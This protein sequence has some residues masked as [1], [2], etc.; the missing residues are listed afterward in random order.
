VK[1]SELIQSVKDG[2]KSF[3]EGNYRAALIHYLQ[4]FKEGKEI[5]L[6]ANSST[7]LTMHDRMISCFEAMAIKNDSFEPIHIQL[8]HFIFENSKTNFTGNFQ[9]TAQKIILDSMINF[10]KKKLSIESVNIGLI[11]NKEIAKKII[12]NDGSHLYL[13]KPSFALDI[14]KESI[15]YDE[16]F[17][18]II[19]SPI[20]LKILKK[21]F[22]AN[23]MI[24]IFFSSIR[25][26]ILIESI[27][28]LDYLLKEEKINKFLLN[29]CFHSFRN[30]FC[31]IEKSQDNSNLEKL[32][33]KV[34]L[35]IDDNESI[36]PLEILVLLSYKPI[37]QYKKV[38]KDFLNHIDKDYFKELIDKQIEQRKKEEILQN[39]IKNITSIEDKTSN[40]V[41]K[42]YE[43][44]P[45]PRWDEDIKKIQTPYIGVIGNQTDKD[46][47]TI[48]IRK[49][50]VAG[51]GTGLQAINIA[52]FDPKVSIDA[53]DLSLN[54]LAYGKRQSQEMNIKN[55]NWYQA[56]ILNLEE[57][58]EKYDVIE[59]GGV[60]HHM[61]NPKKGFN[62]LSKKL[63]KNGFMKI[64]LYS[65]AYRETL[66][67]NKKLLKENKISQDIESI[68]KARLLLMEKEILN[69]KDYFS[70]SGLID[71]LMHE[72]ELDFT[73]EELKDL[74]EEDF[75][76]LG[77]IFSMK[78]KV[79]NNK[80][81]QDYYS[82]KEKI[83]DIN[84]WKKL[85]KEDETLFQS[86]YQ[87]WLQKK[88]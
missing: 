16:D 18:E 8:I 7:F 45:Y 6:N 82:N 20:N 75:D 23:Q 44:N 10:L 87:F 84:N 76:F 48:K 50:L 64:A 83:Y 65:N 21:V 25:S 52:L 57:H 30:E 62:I 22:F 42:Q 4:P 74:Y 27:R 29:L 36:A 33:K 56:D 86:M 79:K 13:D 51:C 41:R 49:I 54:S 47:K 28:N 71:L 69:G 17:K 32:Y 61:K 68:K 85:E 38:T 19:L 5:K 67:P 2:D 58:D 55:I 70:K 40:N 78:D 66:N 11:K 39:D 26:N 63:N 35:K 1:K 12:N 59:A 73:I 31:W 81:F 14:F 37:Y 24:E 60:L 80:L 77:F 15:I 88:Y 3:I 46:F 34:S 43:E 53:I 9:N 72:Q